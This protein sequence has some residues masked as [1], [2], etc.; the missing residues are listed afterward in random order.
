MRRDKII[1]EDGN[2]TITGSDVWMTSWELA[3]LFYTTIPHIRAVIRRVFK[4]SA[5]KEHENS[6]RIRLDNGLWGE[7]Y[8]FDVITMVSFMIDTYNANLFRRWIRKKILSN[9]QRPPC[10]VFSINGY[11]VFD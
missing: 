6:K 11:E 2:V 5:L 7:V 10:V 4:V 9:S 8:S 1:I 3:E